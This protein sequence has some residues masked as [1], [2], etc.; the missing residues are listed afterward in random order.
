MCLSNKPPKHRHPYRLW[1]W[2]DLLISSQWNT[3]SPNMSPSALQL[4]RCFFGKVQIETMHDPSFPAEIES[5]TKLEVARNNQEPNRYL[6]ALTVTLT[7]SGQKR[8]PYT[9][10]VQVIGFFNISADLPAEKQAEIASVNGGSILF[11]VVREMVANVTARGP[12]PA[13][14]LQCLDFRDVEV[15]APDLARAT[16]RGGLSRPAPKNAGHR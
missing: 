16:E 12:W 7:S 14:T 3:S 4:E 10:V 8:A 1:E 9:G 13:V 5:S 2:K 15:E 11:G 6:L